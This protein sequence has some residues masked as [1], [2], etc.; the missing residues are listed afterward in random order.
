[1]Y[2]FFRYGFFIFALA[3]LILIIT[4]F[5][6][7]GYSVMSGGSSDWHKAIADILG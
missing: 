7:A 2:K 1:M 6:S 3:F 5:Y 4:Q